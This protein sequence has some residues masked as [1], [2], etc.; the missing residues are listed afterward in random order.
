LKYS[1][2]PLKGVHLNFVLSSYKRIPGGHTRIIL[3]IRRR[4]AKSAKKS[5]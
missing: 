5:Y 3:N 1:V 4:G 2:K